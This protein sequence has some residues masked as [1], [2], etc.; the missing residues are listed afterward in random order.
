VVVAIIALLTSI[1]LPALQE[2]KDRARLDVCMSNMRQLAIGFQAYAAENRGMLPG[3]TWD[4]VTDN[5]ND[6]TYENSRPL[7]WLG[8]LDGDG[9]REHIKISRPGART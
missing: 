7:C 5:P 1:L 3:S 4:F 2:A 6:P 9:D 8:S